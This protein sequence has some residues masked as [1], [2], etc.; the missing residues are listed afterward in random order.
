MTR[1]IK[2]GRKKG[3]RGQTKPCACGRPECLVEQR[4][5][6]RPYEFA[7]RIFR[8]RKCAATK[9]PRCAAPV[10]R[11]RLTADQL[12]TL[13]ELARTTMNNTAVAKAVG[14]DEGTVRRYRKVQL[15]LRRRDRR[16]GIRSDETVKAIVAEPEDGDKLSRALRFLPRPASCPAPLGVPVILR[17]ELPERIAA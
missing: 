2:T 10:F 16:N 3:P 9:R 12:E 17:R 14:C 4:P 15:A 7:T 5:H 13:L 8:D 6:E 1:V 11:A